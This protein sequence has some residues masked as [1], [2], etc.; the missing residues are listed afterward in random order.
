MMLAA[1]IN[2]SRSIT[3]SSSSKDEDLLKSLE[4][5]QREFLRKGWAV[6][7]FRSE[8]SARVPSSASMT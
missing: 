3:G 4:E 1:D 6:A 2:N 8:A 7:I 5:L